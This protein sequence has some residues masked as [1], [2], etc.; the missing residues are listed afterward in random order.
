MDTPGLRKL[1]SWSIL[2]EDLPHLFPE[3]RALIGKC[4][5]R[6]CAHLDEPGCA[7]QMALDAGDMAPRR[8]RSYVLFYH[9]LSSQ[10]L[11]PWEQA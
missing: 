3:I 10:N 1:T 11:A 7:V 9:E 6:D 5:F 8:Y 2:A 4:R